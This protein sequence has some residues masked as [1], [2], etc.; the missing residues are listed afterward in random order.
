MDDVSSSWLELKA[1][2]SAVKL[3]AMDV[4]G[5]LTDGGIYYTDDGQEFK[6]FNVKDGQGLKLASQLGITLAI[7][8][9]S[10]SSAILHRAQKLGITNVFIGVEN[11][12]E[13]IVQLCQTL[14]LPFSQ[15]AYIGD[16]IN[17][18]AVMEKVYCPLTVADASPEVQAKAIYI[19]KKLGG[20]GAVREICDLLIE[21][22]KWTNIT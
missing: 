12:L 4:D 13:T 11:K 22:K 10:A 5:V 18:L 1:R 6:R 19:T 14:D 9:A 20:Q 16:D 3:L 21:Q 15:V 7:I 2:L 8:S 17:D